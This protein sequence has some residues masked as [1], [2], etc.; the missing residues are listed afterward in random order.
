MSLAKFSGQNNTQLNEITRRL[1]N[2]PS[3]DIIRFLKIFD[4]FLRYIYI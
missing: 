4:H 2:D 1:I 3:Q